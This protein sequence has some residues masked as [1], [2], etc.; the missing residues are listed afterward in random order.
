[1]APV[2]HSKSK[3]TMVFKAIGR[4]LQTATTQD[5]QMRISNRLMKESIKMELGL[6]ESDIEKLTQAMLET[7]AD[8]TD[9]YLKAG[10]E[11]WR[12]MQQPVRQRKM[13]NP[14][15]G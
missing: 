2:G 8:F 6:H 5:L 10:K 1:M 13:K 12:E 4:L 15:R 14:I 3:G 9:V 7:F 11:A